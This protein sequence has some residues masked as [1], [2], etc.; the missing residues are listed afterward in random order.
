M[1]TKYG[2]TKMTINEFEK[3]LAEIRVA[4]T[5]LKVQQ[6]HTYSPGYGSFK[7]DNQLDLQRAMKN[8]H[9]NKNGWSDIGQHFSTF[10]DG[11]IVTGRS[12][13]TTPACIYGQNANSICME[14]VGNFD[15]GGDIM[16]AE[17]R[18]TIIRMTAALCKKFGL[19]IDS[20][21][22]VYHHWYNLATGE[23]NNGTKN[24]KSCP[25]TNFFGGNKV[26]DCEKHFL[27]LIA[28]QLGLS[29]T[30]MAPT[31][32]AT[33]ASDVPLKYVCVTGESLN[34]RKKPD[35]K[36]DKVT[37]REPALLGAVLRVFKV[38]DGWYK[39][40]S[41]KE[42]WVNGKYCHDVKLA[43]VNADTLNVRSGPGKGYP[44]IGSLK[45]GEEVFIE[46]TE[47]G[48]CELTMDE[49]WVSEEFLTIV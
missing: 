40:S 9:V 28:K 12:I 43:K 31:G 47:K 13:E 10:P 33:N 3:W 11:S 30:G 38:K 35:G 27:P 22:I 16:T 48:W 17:H 46:K 21:R 2:F 8:Y 18:T 14:H 29:G 25:G 19:S 15:K 39:I 5:I 23:R 49:R 45:K 37:D 7:G 32:I 42:H 34:I 26:E 24:N 20:N 4:R 44:K 6:H 41:A 36:S 1:E